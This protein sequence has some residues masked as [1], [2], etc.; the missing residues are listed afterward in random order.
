M[1][2]RKLVLLAI[3]GNMEIRN[4][5]RE[6]LGGVSEPTMLR[7][8]NINSDELTK[9]AVVKVISKELEIP[10]AEVLE[11]VGSEAASKV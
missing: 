8:L 5:I 3:R 9:A 2:V 10:E 7:Y 4:K 6:A 11:E 1:K